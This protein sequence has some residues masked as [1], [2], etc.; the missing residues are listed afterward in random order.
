MYLSN[1]VRG[2]TSQPSKIN[3][4]WGIWGYQVKRDLTPQ[5]CLIC[6]MAHTSLIMLH[7]LIGH[8]VFYHLAK[9]IFPNP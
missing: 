7:F 3:D 2:E 1:H 4:K 5:G 6:G 9:T 8:Q